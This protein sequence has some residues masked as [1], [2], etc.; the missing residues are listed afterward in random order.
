MI[1]MIFYMLAHSMKI[2]IKDAAHIK[3]VKILGMGKEQI[4]FNDFLC[5]KV[6]LLQLYGYIN[7]YYLYF[8]FF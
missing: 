5:Y 7:T 4:F 2:N 1:D 3:E 8:K 6:N